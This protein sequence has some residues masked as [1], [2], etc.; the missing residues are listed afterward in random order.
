M[1]RASDWVMQICVS[2]ENT[3]LEAGLLVLWCDGFLVRARD[4]GT[5]IARH[6]DKGTHE[7]G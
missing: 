1:E 2:V 6:A 3:T 4:F 7:S 5:D